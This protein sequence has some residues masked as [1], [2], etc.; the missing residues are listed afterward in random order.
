[1]LVFA[2]VACGFL[3]AESVKANAQ[4]TGESDT[5]VIEKLG[6]TSESVLDVGLQ[7][8]SL[9]AASKLEHPSDKFSDV[10]AS[11]FMFAGINDIWVDATY[12]LRDAASAPDCKALLAQSVTQLLAPTN[13]GLPAS[14][15]SQPGILRITRFFD[16]PAIESDAQM[17]ESASAVVLRH[18]KIHIEID[19]ASGKKVAHCND[20]LTNF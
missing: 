4:S 5:Q 10:S 9:Y 16:S 17:R 8:F 7:L 6:R 3:I 18:T 1:M 14:D 15:I 2:T 19:D 13:P 11:V 20:K 12:R